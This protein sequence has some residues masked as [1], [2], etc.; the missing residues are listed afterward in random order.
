MATETQVGTPQRASGRTVSLVWSLTAVA[1][2]INV[3]SPGGDAGGGDP[4]SGESASSLI[5]W[6]IV[7]VAFAI[8][9]AR[10]CP[11]GW[12]T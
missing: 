6:S 7:V 1:L 2:T 4:P 10:S 12:G 11:G 8:A 5:G 3:S 9:G